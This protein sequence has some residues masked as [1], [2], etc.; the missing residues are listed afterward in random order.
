MGNKKKERHPVI[1]SIWKLLKLR[2]CYFY[3]QIIRIGD[4]EISRFRGVFSAT[5]VCLVNIKF[6]KLK[7]LLSCLNVTLCLYV[8]YIFRIWKIR[9]INNILIGF[10]KYS[11]SVYIRINT[12][13]SISFLIIALY[14]LCLEFKIYN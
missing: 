3:T 14:L 7:W 9:W 11:N 4:I 8:L 10:S 13:D 1:C 2:K 6:L 5:E 12:F